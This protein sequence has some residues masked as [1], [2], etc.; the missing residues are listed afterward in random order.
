[1]FDRR[2]KNVITTPINTNKRN[3]Y[4]QRGFVGEFENA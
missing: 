2:R 3:G 4:K 1:M